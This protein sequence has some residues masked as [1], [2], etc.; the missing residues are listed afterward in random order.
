MSPGDELDPELD[1]ADGIVING[2]DG[3]TGEYL[4]P[5]LD[6]TTIAKLARGEKLD[7]DELDELTGKAEAIDFEGLGVDIAMGGWGIVFGSQDPQADAIHEA[8]KPLIEHRTS[9]CGEELIKVFKGDEG[10]QPKQP[11][12][13]W[14]SKRGVASGNPN[15]KKVPYY[16]LLVG[17]PQQISH[18]F[19]YGLNVAHAVGRLDLDSVEDYAQYAKSVVEVEG[20]AANRAKTA[21]FFGVANSHD[22]ATQLS[23]KRLIKPAAASFAGDMPDWTV[24]TSIAQEA[25]KAT[26]L[27]HLGGDKT[28]SLL[29]TASHGVGFPKGAPE[30]VERQGAILCQDW[31]GPVKQP[32]APTPDHYVAASDIGDD[33]NVKGMVAFFFACFGAGTPKHDSFIRDRSRPPKE[34][35]DAAFTAALP[36]RLLSHPKGSALAVVAHVDRAWGY[37]FIWPGAGDQ[38][39][40]FNEAFLTIAGGQPIGDSRERFSLSWAELSAVLKEEREA[41]E[42]LM[43]DRQVGGIWTACNDRRSYVV[44]G[45]PAAS[46]L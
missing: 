18:R 17:S 16:L 11:Q 33:A 27:E 40:I 32:K 12:I 4:L 6:I 15:F 9:Q 23:S 37:S 28:P 35:A 45:D 24:G 26:L 13:M 21:H 22:R 14:R 20:D 10:C 36:K 25:T 43:T 41:P 42:P 34:I 8:L 31:N 3:S 19:E 46:L 1:P 38:V 2:V 7:P 30:Q 39:G 5:E 44:L 29:V